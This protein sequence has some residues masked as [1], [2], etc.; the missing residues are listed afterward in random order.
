[1]PDDCIEWWGYRAIEGYGYT[2]CIERRR[3]RQAHRMIY[4]ETLGEIPAG[5]HLHHVCRNRACVNPAH[6]VALTPAEHGL[7]HRQLE[8]SRGH[9]M[10]EGNTY[11]DSTGRHHCRK[12]RALA[13][14]RLR[15]RRKAAA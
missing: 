8:C 15:D 7:E 4:E 12:C 5:H 14:Q 13:A 1:M 2:F 6:L 3:M 9:A 10:D 11:F